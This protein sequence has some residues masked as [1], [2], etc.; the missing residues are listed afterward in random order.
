[1]TGRQSERGVRPVD[2]AFPGVTIADAR[3]QDVRAILPR[4]L[5]LQVGD[6]ART[7]FNRGQVTPVTI[8]ARKELAFSQSGVMFRV[9]PPL[10]GGDLDSWYDAGWFWPMEGGDNA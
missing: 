3:A 8:T 7:D 10:H 5:S 1:M 6:A 2:V 9:S 4:G